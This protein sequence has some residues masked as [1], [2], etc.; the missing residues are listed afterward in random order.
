MNNICVS[1][2]VFN[3]NN[4]IIFCFAIRKSQI[5]SYRQNVLSF[6]ATSQIFEPD[7]KERDPTLHPPTI[8]LATSSWPGFR[9]RVFRNLFVFYFVRIAV[10]LQLLLL[11]ALRRVLYTRVSVQSSPRNVAHNP[12]GEHYTRPNVYRVARLDQ[13]WQF[14]SV[15][16]LEILI[17][18][19]LFPMSIVRMSRTCFQ[20]QTGICRILKNSKKNPVYPIFTSQQKRQSNEPRKNDTQNETRAN[21]AFRFL[22]K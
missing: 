9:S 19:F 21:G 18:P 17:L 22:N 16:V 4:S 13:V 14:R 5:F 15:H 7:Q 8:V 1:K 11:H 2:H 20:N 12:G 3:V 10:Y 6:Y